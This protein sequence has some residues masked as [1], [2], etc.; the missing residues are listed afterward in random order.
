MSC[1]FANLKTFFSNFFFKV[2]TYN[3][4]EDS[5]SIRKSL[6]QLRVSERFIST[7]FRTVPKFVWKVKWS[8]Q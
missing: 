6:L 3:F 7:F 1:V 5:K 2:I 8:N 4:F